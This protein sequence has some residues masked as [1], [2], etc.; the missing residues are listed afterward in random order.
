MQ[1]RLL[2]FLEWT[3]FNNSNI[4]LIILSYEFGSPIHSIPYTID[5]YSHIAWKYV[6]NE[7]EAKNNNNKKESIKYRFEVLNFILTPASL[8]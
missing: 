1:F 7:G 8:V 4:N 5:T 3:K 6:W 2:K